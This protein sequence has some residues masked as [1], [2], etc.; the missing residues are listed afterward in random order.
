ME[1]KHESIVAPPPYCTSLPVG[2]RPG[3]TVLPQPM[4]VPLTD[5][6][7]A[8]VCPYCHQSIVTRVEKASGA[9]VWL[10]AATLCVLGFA[11]GCCLIPFCVDDIKV[12]DDRL[13]IL[14]SYPSTFSTRTKFISAPA[15]TESLERSGSFEFSLS[16]RF[17]SRLCDVCS[18]NE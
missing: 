9:M 14:R 12:R 4:M 11:F 1:A 7:T 10:I 18:R 13:S 3:L 8:C 2:D 15:V 6:P 17:S 5:Y 16:H